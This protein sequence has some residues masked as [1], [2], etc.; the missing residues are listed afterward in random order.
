MTQVLHLEERIRELESRIDKLHMNRRLLLDII[1]S[2]EQDYQAKL[3]DLET[4]NSQLQRVNCRYARA[5]MARNARILEL[6]EQL[7]QKH[8]II[9]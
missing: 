9:R 7:Q 5:I 6:E 8:L 2:M 4:K 1:D 3:M